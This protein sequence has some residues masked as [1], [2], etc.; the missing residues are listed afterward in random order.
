MLCY[1]LWSGLK[2]VHSACWAWT[3]WNKDC[4]PFSVNIIWCVTKG[5][6]AIYKWWIS[7]ALD[8]D[9]LQEGLGDH[10]LPS[11]A[12]KTNCNGETSGKLLTDKGLFKWTEVWEAAVHFIYVKLFVMVQRWKAH[13]RKYILWF[14][15]TPDL[16]CNILTHHT[17][18]DGFKA[19]N[20]AWYQT[21]PS[22]W[23]EEN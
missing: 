13:G 20:S 22:L 19:V 8:F 1:V 3:K 18:S 15:V 17:W 14:W 23:R 5:S 21:T 4:I 7:W 9:L 6:L 11:N 2:L 16:S 12:K 10:I